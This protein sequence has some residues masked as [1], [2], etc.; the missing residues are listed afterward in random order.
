MPAERKA[1]ELKLRGRGLSQ[2]AIARELGWHK[3]SVRRVL[4]RGAQG[5]SGGGSA[6]GSS[7]PR[8]TLPVCV[9]S[10]RL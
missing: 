6:A 5:P 8:G 2:R 1:G 10:V 3:E 4:R 7:R 9:F